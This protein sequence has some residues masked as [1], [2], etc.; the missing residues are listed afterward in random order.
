MMNLELLFL[1]TRLS[2]DS[3]FYKMAI[4]HAENTL[5]NHFR[6]DYSCY[7]VVDYDKTNGNVRGKSTAQGFADESAWARGQAWALYG[8]TMCY[9][10]TKDIRF[11]NL[12]EN[13]FDFLFS[14]PNMP[15]D[16]VPYWDFNAPKI[17]DE[18]RD[19]SAAA[20]IASALYELSTFKDGE[21]KS[22]ADK[23]M[24]SLSSA[25]YLAG[26]NE[27]GNFILKHSV[28]SIP[29]NNEI[30]VPLNYADYYFLE[31]LSRKIKI[32]AS[33]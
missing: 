23:I 14:H 20:I 19:A 5:I 22:T 30:D 4:N 29:H 26:L 11:L 17:P 27:N 2:G 6:K 12:A 13:I 16:L 1:A 9:R 7:H 10:E 33:N 32:E 24:I 18:P 3:S 15:N 25:D 28:G 21:Y 31:A 8:F